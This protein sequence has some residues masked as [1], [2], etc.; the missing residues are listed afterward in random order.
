MAGQVCP[1]GDVSAI[2]GDWATLEANWQLRGQEGHT[3][4]Y[5]DSACLGSW[6]WSSSVERLLKKLELHLG[7]DCD[8]AARAG[9]NY[10]AFVRT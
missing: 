1:H 9:K 6:T 3:V 2:Q 10:P 8:I 5:L 4:A 7:A